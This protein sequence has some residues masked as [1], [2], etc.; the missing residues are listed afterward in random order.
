M[1]G[2]AGH[3]VLAAFDL[4]L[5]EQEEALET[6]DAERLVEALRGASRL[7]ETP[8]APR[9]PEGDL[10]AL[11]GLLLRS[12]AVEARIRAWRETILRE[13]RS[14][15]EGGAAAGSYARAAVGATAEQGGGE[16]DLRL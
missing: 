7:V 6:G 9:A 10:E 1:T 14:G 15:V 4:L 12:R 13:L 5:Q 8:E 3:R 2:G 11:D 16:V